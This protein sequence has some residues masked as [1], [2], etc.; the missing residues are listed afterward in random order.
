MIKLFFHKLKQINRWAFF[1]IIAFISL[2]SGCFSS[3]TYSG[4][5]SYPKHNYADLTWSLSGTNT[6]LPSKTS[7]AFGNQDQIYYS[8]VQK[9]G[10]INLSSTSSFKKIKPFIDLKEWVETSVGKVPEASGMEVDHQNRIV[11][12]DKGTGKLLRISSSARKLEVLADSYDG[13]RFSS[14]DDLR[15]DQKSQCYLSSKDSGVIYRVD[16]DSGQIDILN[17][18]VINPEM[19]CIDPSEGRLLFSEP[20]NARILFLSLDG[21]LSSESPQ[22]LID[23]APEV[24]TPIGLAFDQNELLYV[25]FG[26]MKQI[27]IYDLVKGVELKILHL[28]QYAGELRFHSGYLYVGG[29]EFITRFKLPSLRP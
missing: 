19:I 11:I 16:L 28:N 6:N 1:C 25:S 24:V 17:D 21:T 4:N 20:V 29:E 12:A 13:Y 2:L 3:G 18:R 26:D 14:V 15:I 7:L 10:V 8:N 27:R 5:L 22:T 23:F 9:K